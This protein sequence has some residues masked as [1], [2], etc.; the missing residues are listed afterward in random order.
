MD[1]KNINLML[2]SGKDIILKERIVGNNMYIYIFIYGY[3]LYFF[4]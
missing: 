4:L 2:K 3:I 1:V